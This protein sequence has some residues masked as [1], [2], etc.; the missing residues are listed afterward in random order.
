M[1]FGQVILANQAYL[2]LIVSALA[3]L[4]ILRLGGVFID[5][6]FV[7]EPIRLLIVIILIELVL[8]LIID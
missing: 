3:A 1:K 6:A 8:P 7:K 2:A 5:I 4:H